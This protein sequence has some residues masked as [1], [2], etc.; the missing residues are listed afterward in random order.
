MRYIE[1]NK[2]LK[3]GKIQI[4]LV[5]IM[6]AMVGG[7]LLFIIGFIVAIWIVPNE[8]SDGHVEMAVPQMFTGILIGTI[9]FITIFIFTFKKLKRKINKYFT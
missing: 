2:T 1:I 6:S 5:S 8:T 4:I 3:M 9:G 7:V